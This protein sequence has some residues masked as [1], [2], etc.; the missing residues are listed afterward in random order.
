MLTS[1]TNIAAKLHWQNAT[2]NSAA[3][4]GIK[5]RGAY[6][7]VAPIHPVSGHQ[8]RRGLRMCAEEGSETPPP[9]ESLQKFIPAD[10]SPDDVRHRHRPQ[11]LQL[12]RRRQ[13]QIQ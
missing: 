5:M 12:S 11:C 3:T 1:Y 4:D 13:Q 9:I 6:K 10:Q 7:W 8:L 2:V